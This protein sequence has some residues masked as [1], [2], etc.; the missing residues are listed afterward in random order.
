[1][2]LAT[3]VETMQSENQRTA[4]R[5]RLLEGQ[6]EA[7]SQ[8]S[9]SQVGTPCRQNPVNILPRYTYGTTRGGRLKERAKSVRSFK[10][11]RC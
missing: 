11:S 9:D 7:A 2:A 3:Q 10:C 8:G 1:M 5:I 4:H 6:P